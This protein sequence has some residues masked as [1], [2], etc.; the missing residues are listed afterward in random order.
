[1]EAKQIADVL[2]R[3]LDSQYCF[4]KSIQEVFGLFAKFLLKDDV[5]GVIGS[6]LLQEPQLSVDDVASRIK[7]LFSQIP[8]DV[9]TE[10]H[11]DE[12][13]GESSW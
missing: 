7:A 1:M 9:R 3:K 13:E 10:T 4:D 6:A 11:I 5:L 8:F 2:L 12:Y